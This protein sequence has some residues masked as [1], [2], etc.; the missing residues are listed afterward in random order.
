MC[1][2]A[3]IQADYD[4]YVRLYGATMSLEEFARNVWEDPG[5]SKRRR[6]K[7]M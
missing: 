1:Y 2:S 7:A 6:P 4:K 5:P 3:M